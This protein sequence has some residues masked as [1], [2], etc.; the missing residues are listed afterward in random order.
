MRVTVQRLLPS[1]NAACSAHGHGAV[2]EDAFALTR[3]GNALSVCAT[4]PCQ[5]WRRS[6]FGRLSAGEPR[7]SRT[8]FTNAVR[9]MCVTSVSGVVPSATIFA[10]PWDWEERAR[11]ASSRSCSA[12]SWTWMCSPNSTSAPPA[13]ATRE[14]KAIDQPRPRSPASRQRRWCLL[15]EIHSDARRVWTC[16]SARAEL[17]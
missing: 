16:R 10:E 3:A 1:H 13:I 9:A 2:D 12:I 17:G 4:Q 8:R 15:T 14:N 7:S 11:T 6:F 5:T